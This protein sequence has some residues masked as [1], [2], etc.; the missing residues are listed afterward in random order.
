MQGTVPDVEKLR[1]TLDRYDELASSLTKLR[2]SYLTSARDVDAQ[3]D[4]L[5]RSRDGVQRALDAVTDL[6]AVAV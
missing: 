4:D 2:D 3:L 5:A 1:A 6:E